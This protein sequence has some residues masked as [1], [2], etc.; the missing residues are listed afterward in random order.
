MPVAEISIPPAAEHVRTARLV[1]GAAA[2]RCGINEE[3]LDEVRLAVGEACARAV[4]RHE[5]AE[6]SEPVVVRMQDDEKSFTVEVSDVASVDVADEDD[7]LAL[8]MIS[9]LAEHSEV[10]KDEPGTSVTMRWSVP[11]V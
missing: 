11:A 10:T 5:T 4:V 8:A 7:V 1:A 2:R 6:S 3:I 9:A